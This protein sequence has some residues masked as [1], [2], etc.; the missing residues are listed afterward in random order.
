VLGGERV[1]LQDKTGAWRMHKML[2]KLRGTKLERL[3]AGDN[4]DSSGSN[5]RVSC[6]AE[7]PLGALPLD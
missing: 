2:R 1:E 6:V 5:W 4:D 3:G 7:L